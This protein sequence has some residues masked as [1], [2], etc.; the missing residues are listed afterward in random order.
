MVQSI[1]IYVCVGGSILLNYNELYLDKDEW[2]KQLEMAGVGY[3]NRKDEKD[4][5]TT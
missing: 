2:L 3:G 1:Y 5:M 4:I